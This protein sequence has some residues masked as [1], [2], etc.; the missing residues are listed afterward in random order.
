MFSG[1]PGSISSTVCETSEETTAVTTTTL[2]TT[3]TANTTS[4]LLTTTA[5]PTTSTPPTTATSPTTTTLSTPTTSTTTTGTTSNVQ[6]T[7]TPI[8]GV[9]DE[10]PIVIVGGSGKYAVYDASSVISFF[11][12]TLCIIGTVLRVI[13][14]LLDLSNL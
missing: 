1:S 8:F 12:P 7:T 14:V 13:G 9:G 5:P 10:G 6:T 3:T 4:T 11:F 2:S